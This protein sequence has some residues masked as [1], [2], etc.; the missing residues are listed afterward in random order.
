MHV[1]T[2]V[3]LLLLIVLTTDMLRACRPKTNVTGVEYSCPNFQK[4]VA[5]FALIKLLSKLGVYCHAL[6]FHAK[7][8][9][10]L[11][12]DPWESY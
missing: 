2:S 5:L 6:C 11:T 3:T 4:N 8:V 9:F 10:L 12:N 1:A 7:L